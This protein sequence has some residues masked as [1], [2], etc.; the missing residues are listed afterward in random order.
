MPIYEYQ[1][2]ACHH[3][4]SVLQRVGEGNDSLTC[5]KCGAPKP[6]KQFSS[7]ASCCSGDQHTGSAQVRPRFT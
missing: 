7:F 4:F 2:T 6:I 3:R 1:C 5:E